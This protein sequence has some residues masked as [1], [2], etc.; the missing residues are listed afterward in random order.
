MTSSP[1][2]SSDI[3]TVM[4]RR[5]A[6]LTCPICGSDIPPMGPSLQDTISEH[7]HSGSC[8]PSSFKEDTLEI[9]GFYPTDLFAL[10]HICSQIPSLR[11]L[12]ISEF[13]SKKQKH[14]SRT[15]TQPS[16]SLTSH[17]PQHPSSLIPGDDQAT[18]EE[19]NVHMYDSFDPKAEQSD[20]S[21]KVKSGNISNPWVI[22]TLRR[23]F[24]DA[25]L[26]SL[27]SSDQRE[28]GSVFDSVLSALGLK[29]TPIDGRDHDKEGAEGS[30]LS[31]KSTLR[32]SN[33]DDDEKRPFNQLPLPKPPARDLRSISPI[34]HIIQPPTVRSVRTALL[35]VPFEALDSHSTV[36]VTIPKC[37]S[38]PREL[39]KTLDYTGILAKAGLYADE[40]SFVSAFE[41]RYEQLEEERRRKKV[42]IDTAGK[43]HISGNV[44]PGSGIDMGTPGTRYK[45]LSQIQDP[46]QHYC[47]ITT[48]QG[49]E[50]PPLEEESEFS[51][52]SD[53][54][55]L[56]VRL[57]SQTSLP[58]A[59][60]DDVDAGGD[61]STSS[62]DSYVTA[63]PLNTTVSP[64]PQAPSSITMVTVA[65][66][67]TSPVT[68]GGGSP[69]PPFRTSD[70]DQHPIG[71]VNPQPKGQGWISSFF[72]RFRWRSHHPRSPETANLAELVM[73]S[74]ERALSFAVFRRYHS[75]TTRVD[76]RRILI[77]LL[78][79]LESIDGR[80]ITKQERETALKQAFARYSFPH[81]SAWPENISRHT[82]MGV[83]ASE[84]AVHPSR[85]LGLQVLQECERPDLWSFTATSHLRATLLSRVLTPLSYS[86]TST[87]T[88]LTPKVRDS[89]LTTP[90]GV[91]QQ[92]PDSSGVE[93]HHKGLW[94][95]AFF[96]NPTAL[97][98]TSTGNVMI[99]TDTGHVFSVP[100]TQPLKDSLPYLAV[101]KRSVMS[102]EPLPYP[103]R[104]DLKVTIPFTR[105]SPGKSM[106]A[107][108]AITGIA[109]VKEG[110]TAICA[111]SGDVAVVSD[112]QM[113]AAGIAS[114]PGKPTRSAHLHG[115]SGGHAFAHHLR[116]VCNG[117]VRSMKVFDSQAGSIVIAGESISVLDTVTGTQLWSLPPSDAL[118]GPFNDVVRI[119]GGAPVLVTAS[120]L[121]E[122]SAFDLRMKATRGASASSVSTPIF[123]S[124]PHPL[125]LLSIDAQ[126]VFAVLAFSHLDNHAGIIDLR[127]PDAGPTWLPLQPVLSEHNHTRVSFSNSGRRAFVWSSDAPVCRLFDLPSC[128]LFRE[129]E[130]TA[131]LP[132]SSLSGRVRI[133][134]ATVLPGLEFG[135]GA[136]LGHD[137]LCEAVVVDMSMDAKALHY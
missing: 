11:S 48:V 111:E 102:R 108:P 96:G 75:V 106:P 85:V 84:G 83:L 6:T 14:K 66:R 113:F 98:P 109:R 70:V 121:G 123:R 126:P 95:P 61:D 53:D 44:A 49:P 37:K 18:A 134:A 34:I 133:H 76:L 47:R 17:Q 68:V 92:P 94:L 31:R 40:T 15:I 87:S 82:C 91:N 55:S 131:L 7:F 64:Q 52:A 29:R 78:P 73:N 9:T 16:S 12:Y 3:H 57:P 43:D 128:R 93:Q 117:A 130:L 19:P 119:P 59:S 97:V 74:V 136:V 86:L 124:R 125:P 118:H 69:R 32:S 80:E 54:L 25:A 79:K 24:D 77:F 38:N 39:T 120:D 13:I 45:L 10:V 30:S 137:L 27:T 42:A 116:G 129:L 67:Q 21:V 8:N 135:F 105:I 101:P 63:I 90:T 115:V 104:D 51:D 88:T 22:D 60:R 41:R 62:S 122:L 28:E 58:S 112:R 107:P 50:A 26:D 2:Q 20:I 35:K 46:P 114:S 72:D 127:K 103:G 100:H 81:P 71:G 110:Y 132:P 5:R 1:P 89:F 4:S 65:G 56:E 23:S 99:G 33:G 36:V